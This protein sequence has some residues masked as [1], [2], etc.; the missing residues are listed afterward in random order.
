MCEKRD[1]GGSRFGDGAGSCRIDRAAD[2]SR[3]AG[4]VRK[5]GIDILNP[6]GE[7]SIA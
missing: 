3:A 4:R 2:R 5:S 6:D 1:A 7:K